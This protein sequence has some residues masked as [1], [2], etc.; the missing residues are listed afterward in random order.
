MRQLEL[1][2]FHGLRSTSDI[3]E[4]GCGIGRLAYVLASFLDDEGSYHGFDISPDAVAWL[5]EHYEP[6]L[7]NFDFQVVELH[8]PRFRP[9]GK[10]KATG[11]TFPYGDQQ[12]DFACSF[13]VFQHLTLDQIRHYLRE[14][15]RVLR[16]DGR[17][18]ITLVAILPDDED[19]TAAAKPF[20]PVGG[21]VYE[22]MPGH[23]KTG[24]AYDESLLRQ[25]IEEQGLTIADFVLGSWHHGRPAPAQPH[26]KPDT[27][28]I[29]PA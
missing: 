3:V 11:F 6:K 9:K 25:T 27:F 7:P 18:L 16:P 28:V 5:K 24:F 20:Q 10:G 4:I 23:P 2:E 21:G 29:A 1:L 12:F 26:A 19:L 17:A 14:V 13:S 15:K 22:S 8:H